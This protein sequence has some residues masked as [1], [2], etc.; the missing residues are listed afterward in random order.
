M[1]I[2]K[3]KLDLKMGLPGKIV[4]NIGS[5]FRSAKLIEQVSFWRSKTV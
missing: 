1:C 2:M 3:F 4:G 5:K